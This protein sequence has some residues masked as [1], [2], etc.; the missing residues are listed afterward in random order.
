M[1]SEYEFAIFYNKFISD[2]LQNPHSKE[3]HQLLLAK[4]TQSDKELLTLYQTHYKRIY[5]L[6][7]ITLKL[8][9]GLF[10]VNVL[11]IYRFL[12]GYLPSSEDVFIDILLFCDLS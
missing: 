10:S 8:S 5:Y 11:S 9:S 1:N 6:K 2:L 3:M 7:E 12:L 4:K